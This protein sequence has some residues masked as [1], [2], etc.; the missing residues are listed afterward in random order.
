MDEEILRSAKVRALELFPNAS[1]G[2]SPEKDRLRVGFTSQ[3]RLDDSAS[4]DSLGVP[5]EK[6]V[7][8]NVTK[9]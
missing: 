1:V 2:L 5:V 6:Y 9:L 8:G 4:P 7:R 3:E